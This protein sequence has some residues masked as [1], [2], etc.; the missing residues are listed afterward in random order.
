VRLGRGD[1]TFGP[2]REFPVAPRICLVPGLRGDT[3]AEARADLASERCTL[4]RVT[5][6]RAKGPAGHVLSQRPHLG[7]E[8][9]DRGR[10]DV[11]LG[12]R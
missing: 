1:G 8:L 7:T 2:L 5:R 4:G 9:P 12:R 6:R 3:P 10:V 11:V